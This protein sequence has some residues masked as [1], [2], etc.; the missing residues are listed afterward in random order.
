MVILEDIY[1][2]TIKKINAMI[3]NIFCLLLFAG[4]LQSCGEDRVG[5][6]PTDSKS[7]DKVENVVIKNIP[8]GAQLSYDLPLDEDLL[9]VE[10]RY[11]QKGV[12]RNVK[13]SC[14]ESKLIIGGF[15]DENE[16]SVQLYSVDRSNN[17]SEPVTVV[18]KPEE[19]PVYAI[20]RSI[21]LNRGIGG[22]DIQ[23]KNQL[24][25]IINLQLY[26]ADDEGQLQLVE[27]LAS[28]AAVGTFSLRGFDD[29]ERRF[30]AIVKDRWDNYS[31]TVSGV[32]TPRF[33]QLIPKAGYKRILLTEDNNTELGGNWAWGKMFDDVTG[34]DNNG[35]HVRTNGSGHG[36]Y[37]TIDLGHKV[38]LTRYMLWQR[39]G[40][41]PYTQNNPKRWR[42]YGRAEAPD[43]IYSKHTIDD[44]E[45]WKEGFRNDTENWTL[46]MTCR[47]EKP[48]GFDN[49]NVTELDKEYA[50]LGHDFIFSEDLPAMR[51]IRFTIDETWGGGD[52]FNCNEL[53]FYGK[54]TDDK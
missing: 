26:A 3:K 29:K 40:G 2:I 36:V 53:A 42:V 8:G 12:V 37:F 4:L 7:P 24:N 38:E 13:A 51:Y 18:I 19:N 41:W 9:F 5:Q 54:I 16:H 50:Y 43:L 32:F 45:Y 33:E 30:A 47:T 14:Y 28:D 17:Y 35:W 23:W 34:V 10:A 52:L 1:R 21:K 44:Q 27:V 48:S 31:D 25:T 46:L 11:E 39:G 49:P 22:I 15:G 20:S 6:V